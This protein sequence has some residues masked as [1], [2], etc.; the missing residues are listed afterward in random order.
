MV[1]N[2]LSYK[3]CKYLCHI[4]ML[5]VENFYR[6]NRNIACFCNNFPEQEKFLGLF[7]KMNII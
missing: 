6:I 4:W 1:I 5:K 3:I 7:S 2:I